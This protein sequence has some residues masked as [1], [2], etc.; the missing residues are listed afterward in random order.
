MVICVHDI[1]L[2]HGQYN[3]S[4]ERLLQHAGLLCRVNTKWTS[5]YLNDRK[6]FSEGRP[7]IIR[8]A[9]AFLL[10]F[11]LV[12]SLCLLCLRLLVLK[13]ASRRAPGPPHFSSLILISS[14]SYI[15]CLQTVILNLYASTCIKI[16]NNSVSRSQ[17]KNNVCVSGHELA[18]RKV[19]VR[20]CY[21]AV[22]CCL[23]S[24]TTDTKLLQAVLSSMYQKAGQ[25]SLCCS[26]DAQTTLQ[27]T[28]SCSVAAS[29]SI[30]AV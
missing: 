10:S 15:I 9:I 28:R 13:Y 8:V 7:H 2:I 16:S 4:L 21:C 19:H 25:Q 27:Y 26:T 5:K 3:T 1:K 23:M 20:L 12:F 18:I 30:A 11:A 14:L 29:A 24:C 17:S 6:G 22:L